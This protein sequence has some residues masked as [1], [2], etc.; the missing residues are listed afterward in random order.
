MLILHPV[1]GEVKSGTGSHGEEVL[2]SPAPVREALSIQT[3]I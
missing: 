1:S 2:L 3:S